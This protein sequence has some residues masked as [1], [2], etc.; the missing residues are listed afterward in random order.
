MEQRG[1]SI[2][3]N[4]GEPTYLSHAYSNIL[5][6]YKSIDLTEYTTLKFY[7]KKGANHGT[8]ML[9]IDGTSILIVGYNSFSTEWVEYEV[10]ISSYD[11][12][13]EIGFGG[14]YSDNTGSG[15]SNTQYCNI[16]LIT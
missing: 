12:F 1:I 5:R 7:A 10:D 14:G 8:L 11:G 4:N 13:H 16:R 15:G 2:T 9:F 6:W 3:G